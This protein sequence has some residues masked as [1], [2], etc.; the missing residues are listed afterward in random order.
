MKF[1]GVYDMSGN[2]DDDIQKVNEYI[3]KASEIIKNCSDSEIDEIR[4]TDCIFYLLSSIFDPKPPFENVYSY[5]SENKTRAVFIEAIRYFITQKYDFKL[6]NVEKNLNQF[7]RVSASYLQWYDNGMMCFLKGESKGLF[8]LYVDD[9][10]Y[11]GMTT[12][13]LNP[14]KQVSREDVFFIPLKEANKIQKN[15]RRDLTSIK[16]AIHKLNNLLSKR[17]EDESKYQSLFKDNPWMFG[18]LQFSQ[19]DSHIPLD[20]A[21]IPD[22]TG[23]RIRDNCRDVI[24]IKQPFLKIFNQDGKFS[25]NFLQAFEQTE[26]YV[27][28][29]LNNRQYLMDKGLRFENPKGFLLVGFNLENDQKRKLLIKQRRS[30]PRITILTYNDI[31]TSAKAALQNIDQLKKLDTKID[32]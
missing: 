23:V 17:C 21:K 19:I 1:S 2:N 27:D 15:R 13:D 31:L 6:N 9:Q 5:L 8:I 20:D 25:S 28:F 11:V 32:E 14:D 29:T 22:F 18:F 16:K 4:N 12:K 30:N 10:Q 24:E 3:L 26:G 7:S